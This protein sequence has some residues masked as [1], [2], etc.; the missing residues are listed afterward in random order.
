MVDNESSI[1]I[2][3]NYISIAEVSQNARE[4]NPVIPYEKKRRAILQERGEYAV[5]PQNFAD[6]MHGKE[7]PFATLSD[8]LTAQRRLSFR[9]AGQASVHTVQAGEI[10]EGAAGTPALRI[11]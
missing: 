11:R 6:A 4:T 1:I 9:L 7:R 8:G 5:I 3:T 10:P 2:Y